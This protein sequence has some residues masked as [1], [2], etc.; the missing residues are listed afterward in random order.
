MPLTGSEYNVDWIISSVCNIHIARD[1]RW[2]R[3]FTPFEKPV[4]IEF[5]GYEKLPI[6]GVG[7]VELPVETDYGTNIL[8]L[9][10]VK[11]VPDAPC[12]VCSFVLLRSEYSLSIISKAHVLRS[13]SNNECAAIGDTPVVPRLRLEGQNA[14]TTMMQA[15]D[16]SRL[17]QLGIS[18]LDRQRLFVMQRSSEDKLRE[19]WLQASILITLI[20]VFVGWTTWMAGWWSGSVEYENHDRW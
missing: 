10:N 20:F 3:N 18:G 15:V 14:D 9:E 19:D 7:T 12:N 17:E 13:R 6:Y 1:Q 11:Y 2:F 16:A 5:Y 4:L 8:I